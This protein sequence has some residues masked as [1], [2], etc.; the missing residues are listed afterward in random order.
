[1]RVNKWSLAGVPVI[2]DLMVVHTAEDKFPLLQKNWPS[3]RW[4]A[5]CGGDRGAEGRRLAAAFETASSWRQFWMA[6]CIWSVIYPARHIEV[7]ILE[8]EGICCPSGERDCSLQRNNQKVLEE[9]PSIAIGKTFVM[10]L[11]CS[12]SCS[13]VWGWKRRDDWISSMKQRQFHYGNDHRVR[14]TPSRRVC[15]FRYDIEGAD[16]HCCRATFTFNKKIF[17]L[18]EVMLSSAGSMQKNPAFNLPKPRK[19]TNLYLS[20]GVGLRVILQ[21]IQVIPFSLLW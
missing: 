17:V 7:Q 4:R 14:W 8:Q 9:S 13:R 10:K 5:R 2:P 16:L 15:F 6:L 21:S 3:Y 20:G 12:R 1:M 18:A 11:C 19:I